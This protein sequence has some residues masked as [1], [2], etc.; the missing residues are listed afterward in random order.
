MRSLVL[1]VAIAVLC[2]TAAFSDDVSDLRDRVLKA[3]A[4]DPADLKKLKTHTLKAKGI[5]RIGP[6]PSPATFEMSAVWPGQVRLQWEFGVGANKNTLI[7]AGTDDRGWKKISDM[8]AIDLS[9]EEFNDFRSDTYAIWVS[10]LSTLSDVD[11]KLAMAAPSK[12]NGE[13][14]VGL[15]VS[16]R[17]LP[18]IT[19]YFDEKTALLRKMT[20][21]SRDAGVTLNKEIIYEGHKDFNGLMMPTK[22]TTMIQNREMLTWNEMEFAFPEKIEA[23]VF[24][25]P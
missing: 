23:K 15:K 12:V 14:V 3:V 18:E 7:V 24:E 20:Y 17:S 22:Q 10:T 13:P 16:R 4:K 19:L 5:S 2:P 9:V 11:S 6:E 8:K 1:I 21:K 25:K